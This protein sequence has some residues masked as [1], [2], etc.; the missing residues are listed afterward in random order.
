MD[1]AGMQGETLLEH[2]RVHPLGMLAKVGQ[3]VFRFQ[4][5]QSCQI[6]AFKLEIKQGTALVKTR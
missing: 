3:S 2:V 5:E 1:S 4:I 6:P